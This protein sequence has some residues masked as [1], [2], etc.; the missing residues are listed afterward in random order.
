VPYAD[1][2]DL[3]TGP[4]PGRHHGWPTWGRASWSRSSPLAAPSACA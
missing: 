4:G 1:W 3:G 2:F